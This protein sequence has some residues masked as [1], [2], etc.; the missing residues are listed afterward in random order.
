MKLLLTSLL[1]AATTISYAQVD[2]TYASER[3]DYDWYRLKLKANNTFEYEIHR[4]DKMVAVANGRYTISGDT[5]KFER[6]FPVMVDRNTGEPITEQQ[7][8]NIRFLYDRDRIERVDVYP[9]TFMYSELLKP[10]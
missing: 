3:K 1:L 5:L 9:S 7:L 2:G 4:T 8:Q 10:R 6:A